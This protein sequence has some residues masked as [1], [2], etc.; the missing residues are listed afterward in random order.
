MTGGFTSLV[1]IAALLI[2]SKRLNDILRRLDGIENR[3]TNIEGHII[4]FAEKI[5]RLEVKT[6]IHD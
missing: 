5:A 6:G 3:L 2:N 4:S 1:C